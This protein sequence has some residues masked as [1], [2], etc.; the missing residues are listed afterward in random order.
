[1]NENITLEE[2]LAQLFLRYRPM[3][4]QLAFW[5]LL[6][7]PSLQRKRLGYDPIQHEKNMEWLKNTKAA[8]YQKDL[9]EKS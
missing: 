9:G 7:S 1:M 5:R 2:K 4:I 3:E 8:A 6:R